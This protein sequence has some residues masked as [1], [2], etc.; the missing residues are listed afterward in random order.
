M[1][2]VEETHPQKPEEAKFSTEKSPF[3]VKHL[4][5]SVDCFIERLKSIKFIGDVLKQKS[6][7]CGI[8]KLLKDF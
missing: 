1:N 8:S 3:I 6:G 4:I 5:T 2:R 7:D